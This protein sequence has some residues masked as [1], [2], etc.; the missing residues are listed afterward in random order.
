[1]LKTTNLITNGELGSYNNAALQINRQEKAKSDYLDNML[2]EQE[3]QTESFHKELS[4]LNSALEPL[5]NA[6]GFLHLLVAR[7]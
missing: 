7:W 1:M 4:K 6:V 5:N 2:L 3:Q